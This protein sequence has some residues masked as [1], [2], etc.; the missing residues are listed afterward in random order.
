MF[1]KT[2]ETPKILVNKMAFG[3]MQQIL[4]LQQGKQ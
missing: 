3:R 1:L 4:D 2:Q